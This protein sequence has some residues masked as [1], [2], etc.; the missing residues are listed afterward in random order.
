MHD[1]RFWVVIHVM[2]S[3]I[4]IEPASLQAMKAMKAMK[5]SRTDVKFIPENL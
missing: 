5:A 1:L 4:A 3:W 2:Q